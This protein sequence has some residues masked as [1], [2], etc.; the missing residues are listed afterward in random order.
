MTASIIGSFFPSSLNIHNFHPFL[1]SVVVIQQ[2]TRSSTRILGLHD[3]LSRFT[4]NL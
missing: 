4:F 1:D 3:D 2:W